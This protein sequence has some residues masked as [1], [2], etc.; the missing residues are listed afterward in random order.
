[1][2]ILDKLLGVGTRQEK[3]TPIDEAGTV[4]GFIATI[5]KYIELNIENVRLSA[6]EKTSI[7][8]TSIAF[9]AM[10]I[11]VGTI[12]LF[13]ISIGIG[14]LLASTIAPHWAYMFVAGFYVLVL[15]LIIVFKNRLFL[16]PITKFVT[17]LLLAPPTPKEEELMTEDDD[18]EDN[19]DDDED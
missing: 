13:F 9:V 4:R 17:R 16:Y 3:K 12:S 1:M 15:I 14:H 10:V 2:S 18:D 7:L 5:Q 6:A 8:F 11:I 19:D